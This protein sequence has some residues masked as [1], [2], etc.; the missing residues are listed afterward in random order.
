MKLWVPSIGSMYQRVARVAGLGP[1]LLADEAVI[2]VR[3]R[4]PRPDRPLDRRVGL[5]DERPVGLGRDLEVAPEGA[6]G[7]RVGLVAGGVSELEP[8]VELR[9][10]CRAGDSPTTPR[11]R[12][13][14]CVHDRIR[15]PAGIPE[16]L[17][18]DLEADPLAE[19][20]DL[21]ARPDRR[22][23]RQVGVG[24]RAL[25]GEAVAAR[26]HPTDDLAA[27]PDRLVP[28]AD[29]A[30]VVEDEAAQPLPRTGRLGRDER[31]AT[32]EVDPC[33][34]PPRTRGRPRTASR[35]A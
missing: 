8:A 5:G 3:G 32:D 12:G 27:D 15:S 22:V 31:V 7:E 9:L 30:R 16:R 11:R 4:D 18:D 26:R 20:V 17:A 10:R 23:R 2:G 6:A 21:A 28:E 13:A 33:R 25:D 35:P 14:S 1:V 29:R 24:D 19:D 34:A